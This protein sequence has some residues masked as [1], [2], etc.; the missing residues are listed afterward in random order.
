[1]QYVNLGRTGLREESH[2]Q[3]ALLAEQLS[4]SEEEIERLEEPYVPHP[5]SGVVV[6]SPA[7]IPSSRT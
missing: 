4:L 1:M 5:V 6:P 3:D 2:L 7:P